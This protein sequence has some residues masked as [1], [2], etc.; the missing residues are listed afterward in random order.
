VHLLHVVSPSVT[1]NPAS[2]F[3]LLSSTTHSSTPSHYQYKVLCSQS[4]PSNVMPGLVHL[5][6]SRGAGTVAHEFEASNHFTDRE[7][8]NDFG[9]N[10]ASSEP[11][12]ARHASDAV[13][14]VDG[15]G[16]AGFGGT[17]KETQ[18]V[19]GGVDHGLKVALNS[20]HVPGKRGQY[21]G[22]EDS[23]DRDVHTVVPCLAG[24][25]RACRVQDQL[26]SSM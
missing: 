6:M 10:N 24:E 3:W 20:G 9:G 1:G 8:A 17:S 18:G 14:D 22:H 11:L 21:K 26:L 19:A 25:R 7:K 5:M 16:G 12:C 23:T 13:E 2:P 15:L 4:F